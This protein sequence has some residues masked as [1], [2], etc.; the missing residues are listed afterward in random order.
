MKMP[1]RRLILLIEEDKDIRLILA[2]RLRSHGY[3]VRVAENSQV[4]LRVLN[5]I[6][7]SAIVL[8]TELQGSDRFALLES[9]QRQRPLIPII[10]ISP[11]AGY[12]HRALRA[13]AHAFFHKPLDLRA[14]LIVL[15]RAIQPTPAAI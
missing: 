6:N 8:D 11:Y 10:V 7:L 3:G 12:Q 9:I 2:D 14:L 13:G 1:P 15:E 5:R 4:A